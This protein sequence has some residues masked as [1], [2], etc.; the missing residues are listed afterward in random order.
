MFVGV[1][2]AARARHVRERQKN[3]H[4][5]IFIDR[6]DAVGYASAVCGLEGRQRRAR[7]D[8]EQMLVR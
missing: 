1:G 6:I 4:C 3:A 8:A 7:A 2:A 5:I